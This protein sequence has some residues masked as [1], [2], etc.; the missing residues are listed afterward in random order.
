M[1]IDP[2]GIAGRNYSDLVSEIWQDMARA[3]FSEDYPK[4]LESRINQYSC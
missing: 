2:F 1:T 4:E 3:R